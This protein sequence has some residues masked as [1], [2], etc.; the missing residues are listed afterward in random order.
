MSLWIGIIATCEIP[1]VGCNYCV[2]LSFLDVFPVKEKHVH[3]RILLL[4][5]SL[6]NCP[7]LVLVAITIFW[8]HEP[9]PGHVCFPPLSTDSKPETEQNQARH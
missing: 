5:T 2:F 8:K 9:V 6:L 7:S 4:D 3:Q 1:V